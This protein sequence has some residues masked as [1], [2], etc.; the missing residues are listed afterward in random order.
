M[1]ERHK[2]YS[3]NRGAQRL[4]E[5]YPNRGDL[6]RLAEQRDIDQGYL[7][8]IARDERRPGTEL[9]RKFWEGPEQIP[10]HWWDEPAIESPPEVERQRIQT[11]P[12]APAP[13]RL[14]SRPPPPLADATE[15]DDE[16]TR[17][18]VA[19]EGVKVSERDR[20]DT[21]KDPRAGEELAPTPKPLTVLDVPENKRSRRGRVPSP[22]QR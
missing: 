1:S 9:R 16:P 19:I 11:P 12:E 4:L 6:T 8:R 15:L 22:E 17:R 21:D 10:M 5:L 2:L 20:V 14:S 3:V 18:D 7:S 13:K